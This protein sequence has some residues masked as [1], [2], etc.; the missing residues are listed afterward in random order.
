MTMWRAPLFWEIFPTTLQA[1]IFALFSDLK[2]ED[3]A[4]K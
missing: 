1:D 4:E 2:L 3:E